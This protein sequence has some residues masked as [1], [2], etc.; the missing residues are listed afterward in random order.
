[1]QGLLEYLYIQNAYG[2][3]IIVT[4]KMIEQSCDDIPD[5]VEISDLEEVPHIIE[6]VRDLKLSLLPQ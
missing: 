4:V 6:G 1:M 2:T 3:S 5:S